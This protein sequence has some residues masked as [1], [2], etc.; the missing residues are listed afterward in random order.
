MDSRSF[1][2]NESGCTL[3]DFP[4]GPAYCQFAWAESRAI[5]S[6]EMQ[7]S[8]TTAI[9]QLNTTLKNLQMPKQAPRQPQRATRPTYQPPSNEYGGL[10]IASKPADTRADSRTT[11]LGV[12]PGTDSNS[13]RTNQ[14]KQ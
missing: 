8:L 7:K 10:E 4:V 11:H 12:R 13:D 9:N 2:C 5:D 3:H 6:L 14:G 1:Y